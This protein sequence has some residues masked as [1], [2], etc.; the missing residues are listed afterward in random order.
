MK[1]K[2]TILFLVFLGF[3]LLFGI[4]GGFFSRLEAQTPKAKSYFANQSQRFKF[5]IPANW[6]ALKGVSSHD[7]SDT[8]YFQ[9]ADGS[10]QAVRVVLTSSGG[11]YFF[12]KVAE[13]KITRK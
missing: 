10:I 12:K 3:L 8:L 5:S 11:E 4:A 1:A 2:A 7:Q 6:G 13:A 9:G